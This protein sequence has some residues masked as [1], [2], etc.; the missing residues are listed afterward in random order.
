MEENKEQEVEV[1][2]N[3]EL[4]QP[5]NKMENNLVTQKKKRGLMI[6]SIFFL[7]ISTF[8]LFLNIAVMQALIK[9]LKS[10]EGKEV[11]GGVIFALLGLPFVLISDFAVGIVHIIFIIA[12]AIKIGQ[13]R[14][15]K[16]ERI[17]FICFIALTVLYIAA[18]IVFFIIL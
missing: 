3:E 17:E 7:V 6:A 8:L 13:K 10:E 12:H 14:A 9:S 5:V 4:Q 18:N 2:S 15:N 11:V 16:I 1:I